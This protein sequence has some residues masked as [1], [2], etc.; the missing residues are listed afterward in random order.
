MQ[1]LLTAPLGQLVI[2]LV[3]LTVLIGVGKW[4]IGKL[5]ANSVQQELTA[6]ELLSKFRELHSQGELT[7][8]EFRTIKATLAA[9]LQQ[10]LKDNADKG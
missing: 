2:W 3:L 4:G 6:G 7:D 5:C 8:A 9:R 10:E 1:S